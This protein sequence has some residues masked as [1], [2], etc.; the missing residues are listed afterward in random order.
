[1]L[2]RSQGIESLMIDSRTLRFLAFFLKAY[3]LR[4]VVAVSL[5]GLAGLLEGVGIVSLI[6]IL[7]VADGRGTDPSGVAGYITRGLAL[8]GLEP[9]LTVLLTIL[10]LAILA[11][12]AVFWVAMTQVRVTIIWVV[13][14]LRARLLSALLGA[15]LR[16][17]VRV[18]SGEWAN[19]V[20]QEAHAAGAA[21]REG[22]EIIAAFFPITA[23]V[24]L[25]TL[26][27][28]QTSLF[29]LVSGA[30]LIAALRGFVGLARRSG[31]EQADLMRQL[32]GLFV[33]AIGGLKPIKA[34]A[35]ERL[36]EPILDK[37]IVSLD[38]ASRRGVYANE[39]TRF[40]QEPALTLLLAVGVYVLFEFQGL[41]LATI[42]VLAFMFYRIMQHL[43]TLQ[44][45]YQI[46]VVG[47][48]SFWSLMSRIEEAERERERPH[49]G[50]KPGRLKHGVRLERV[51]FAYDRG[52]L[53]LDEVCLDISAGALVAIVGG[54]GSGKT[55]LVDLIAGLYAPTGGRILIDGVDL[56]EIDLTA[57]RSQIGY[58]P[59]E[60]LLLNESIRYNVTLGD[61][62]ISTEEVERALRLAGAWG[63]V[64]SDPQ[65]VE[66]P[67]GE[68][69]AKLSGGQRQRIA[70]ARALVTRPSILILDEVTT[71]LDPATEAEICET[72]SSL[73]GDVTI[74]SISHQP[75]MR[76]VADETWTMEAG[77]LTRGAAEATTGAM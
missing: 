22:C 39:N 20:T 9:T 28:W 1:M 18:R 75:A 5:L 34:M 63:F 14:S 72:L 29:A 24:V 44:M 48:A 74:V 64:H 15:R 41:P 16:L 23:Y 10:F 56:D 53:V 31:T 6:P 21:Y 27:S 42:V 66:A 13:R 54:S 2:V 65:G 38:E 55:T 73:R 68:R 19:A 76:A 25:A 32:A 4:S 46:L 57:W 51:S 33:D 45:R 49:S 62:S 47:E 30:A 71:A 3:P 58:V 36:V 67:V 69:G 11:K 50:V 59:Q 77:R 8:V 43:N 70:I 60:M 17:F 37:S 12:A 40:F 35:K 7:Q 52:P 61:P 26:I